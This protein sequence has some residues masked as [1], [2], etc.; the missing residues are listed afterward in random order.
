MVTPSTAQPEVGVDEDNTPEV[1]RIATFAVTSFSTT[2]DQTG[3][4]DIDDGRVAELYDD[5]LGG[6]WG[7]TVTSDISVLERTDAEGAHLIDDGLQTACVL[8]DK[9]L[10]AW[11]SSKDWARTHRL[12]IFR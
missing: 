5:F 1:V 4:R 3:W 9:L 2:H 12:P 11:L 7:L 8:R 10:P 6:K